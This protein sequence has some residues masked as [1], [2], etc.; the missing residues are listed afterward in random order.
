MSHDDVI[1]LKSKKKAKPKTRVQKVI[2]R[3]RKGLSSSSSKKIKGAALLGIGDTLPA[4]M[5]DAM[6]WIEV[7][8]MDAV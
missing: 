8:G 6:T 3:K 1:L 4:V 2:Q 5:H 7:K